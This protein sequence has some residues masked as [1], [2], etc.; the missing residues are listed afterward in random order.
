M[1]PVLIIKTGSTVQSLTEKGDFEDWIKAAMGLPDEYFQVVSVYEGETLPLPL[2]I[3]GI[4]IT[5]SPAMVTEREAWSELTADY[6]EKQALSQTP[7]LGI[8]Y[9]HQLLAH[10]LGG[11]V[12]YHPKGREIG[13]VD[14]NLTDAARNDLLFSTLPS[15]F[16][17]HVSHSQTAIKLPDGAVILAD[18]DFES[19]Q[20]VW[21]GNKV[22]GVQF[23][24]EFDEE[25]IQGYIKERS[26]VI[27]RE[28]LDPMKLLNSTTEAQIATD[29]LKRFVELIEY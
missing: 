5:G 21:Y 13:T 24:P 1:K 3:S 7:V 29:L 19:H 18:N 27:R 16:K 26:E 20:A 15:S 9:G 14:I 17:A 10:A 2:D 6:L 11:A 25:I 23:H 4:V 12:G 8:C 28:G 22:W